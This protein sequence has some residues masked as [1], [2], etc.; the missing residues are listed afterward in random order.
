MI[1]NTK[2]S[3]KKNKQL[4]NN[5]INDN[6]NVFKNLQPKDGV[7]KHTHNTMAMCANCHYNA[8]TYGISRRTYLQI[9][10][11]GN[12]HAEQRAERDL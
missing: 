12:K 1:Q 8:S 9:V 2:K 3:T 11:A 10:A 7:G 4:H 6:T 5:I